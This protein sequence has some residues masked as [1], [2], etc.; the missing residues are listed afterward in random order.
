MPILKEHY[1]LVLMDTGSGLKTNLMNS[2]LRHS[3]A[4]VVVSNA[5]IDAL[6]E[7]QVTLGGCATTV[8]S[9][10]WK[11][12]C[13]SSTTQRGK[14]VIDVDKAVEQF[15]RQ[16][17]PGADLR[18]AVRHPIH[19]QRDHVGLMSA[20]VAAAT[21]K[22]RPRS[23]T[24]FRRSPR[25]NFLR[26]PVVS[27][28]GWWSMAPRAANAVALSRSPSG[29]ETPGRS[30]VTVAGSDQPPHR[31]R[32]R[33]GR[34][35]GRPAGRDTGQWTLARPDRPLKPGDL[36][37]RCPDRR[38]GDPGTPTRRPTERYRPVIEDVVDAV[39]AAASANTRPFDAEAAPHPPGWVGLAAGGTALLRRAV[40]CVGGQWLPLVW[41]AAAGILLALAALGALWSAA[42]RWRARPPRRPGRS[43]GSHGRAVWRKSFQSRCAPT[44]RTGARCG[45][46]RSDRARSSSRCGSPGGT[47]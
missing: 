8:I 43:C 6:G 5:S 7:T 25:T 30:G 9:S 40:G 45:R 29:A 31:R 19:G 47:R 32:R 44:A 13:W 27:R 24:C 15:S 41:C 2:I 37:G 46:R 10:C 21:S 35:A 39:A 28:G 17:R 42:T 34:S 22:W 11:P 20:R 3:R 16:I 4:L 12:P 14:P 36:T 38:R 18:D 26:S 23:P 33:H 1:S